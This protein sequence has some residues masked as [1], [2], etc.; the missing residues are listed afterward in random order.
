MRSSDNQQQVITKTGDVVV[1]VSVVKPR[2]LLSV[3][4]LPERHWIDRV[5]DKPYS[6]K[7]LPMGLDHDSPAPQICSATRKSRETDGSMLLGKPL[8]VGDG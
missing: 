5:V 1:I 7:G 8:T 3:E 6:R 4:T 2:V